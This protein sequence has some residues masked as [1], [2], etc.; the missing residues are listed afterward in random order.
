MSQLH[1]YTS[2]L[3]FGFPSHLG[4]HRPLSRDPCAVQFIEISASL[5]IHLVWISFILII[6]CH[7]YEAFT[8]GLLGTNAHGKL[9]YFLF[10]YLLKMFFYIGVVSL[11][12]EFQGRRSLVGCDPWGH[13]ELDVTERLTHTHTH[14]QLFNSVMLVSGVQQRAPARHIHVSIPFQTLFPVRLLPS[15]EQSSL[16]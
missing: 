11:P 7:C 5:L 15:V 4:H 1:V 6:F 8:K 9:F 3:F 14:T 13:R 12:G 2:P 16:C 10:V